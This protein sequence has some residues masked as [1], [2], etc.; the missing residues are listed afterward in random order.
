MTPPPDFAALF[1]AAKVGDLAAR[2]ELVT[3][4]Y[5]RILRLTAAMLNTFPVIRRR[6]EVESVTNELVLELMK[7]LFEKPGVHLDSEADFFKLAGTVLRNLLLDEVNKYRRR[8]KLLEQRAREVGVTGATA[9]D[10]ASRDSCSPEALDEWTRFH[11]QVAALPEDERTVVE[12]HLLMNL[13]QAEV[14]RIQGRTPRQVSRTYN[15][16]VLKLADYL[17]TVG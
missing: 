6:R 7:E 14:A 12:M 9:A 4:F 11:K 10:A 2:N 3:H 1:S 5:E 16:A 13:T 8:N 17:P 15:A